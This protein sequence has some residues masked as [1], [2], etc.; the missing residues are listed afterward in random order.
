M[1]ELREHSTIDPQRSALVDAAAA[2]W[3]RPGFDTLLSGPT[4]PTRRNGGDL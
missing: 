4:R 2:V 1:D 3:S